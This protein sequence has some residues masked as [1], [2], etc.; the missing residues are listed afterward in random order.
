MEPYVHVTYCDDIRREIGNKKTL[1]GIYGTDLFVPEIP[2][3]ISKLCLVI[4]VVYPM[5]SPINRLHIRIL[6]DEDQVGDI[7]LNDD[8]LARD[9]ATPA[10]S[11]DAEPY[12]GYVRRRALTAEL[13]ISPFV[14]ERPGTIRVVADT[15]RGEYRGSFL[16]VRLAPKSAEMAPTK[17]SQSARQKSASRRTKT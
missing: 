14:I 6:R 8:V 5:D 7:K 10:E 17:A 12:P 16:R 2:T 15:D 11:K 13:V 3:V 4:Q 9:D 1:V